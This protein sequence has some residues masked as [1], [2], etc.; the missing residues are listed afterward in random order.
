MS[1]AFSLLA[2][3]AFVRTNRGAITI[4]PSIRPSLWVWDGRAL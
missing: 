2:R 3:D 4:Y 1:V